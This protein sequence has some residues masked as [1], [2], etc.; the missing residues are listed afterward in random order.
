MKTLLVGDLHLKARL[1]LPM[2]TKEMDELNCERIIFLG[3]YVDDW[4]CNN[5]Q[6]FFDEL[7]YL[8]SWKNEMTKKNIKVINLIGNH[9]AP[10]ITGELRAYSLVKNYSKVADRLLKLGIQ[11]AYQLDD[12]LVSHAG[13]CWGQN[14][15]DWHLRIIEEKD[16]TKLSQLENQVGMVRGGKYWSGSPIWADFL[17]L[18]DAPNHNY[19]NQIVGHTPQSRIILDNSLNA[20]TKLIGID[21]FSLSSKGEYPYYNFRGNGDM[22]LYDNGKLKIIETEWGNPDTLEKLYS[23]R[24]V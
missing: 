9:D 1:I 4:N 3:D 17:E 8:I 12:F 14:L 23:Q 6:L 10:Y 21:T 20:G 16:I 2:V 11:V 7:D 5:P 24:G 18:N 22:L 13:Y 19:L 15:L